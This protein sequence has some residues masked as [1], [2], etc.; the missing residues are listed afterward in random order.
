MNKPFLQDRSLSAIAG[1]WAETPEERAQI[2]GPFSRIQFRKVNLDSNDELKNF[3]LKEGWQPREWNYKK[4][5]KQKGRLLKDDQ[6]KPIVT[7]PKI[8]HDDPF[9]GIDGGLGRLASKRVQARSRKSILEG[10]ERSVRAD[11][12]VSQRITGIA[13][14]GR[15]THSGIVNVPGNES[16]FGVQMRKVF[17]APDPFVLVGTDSA[18]CQDRMLLGRANEYGVNDPVFEDMLLNGN[19]SKGTDSHSR[20]ATELN[21]VFKRNGIA[22]LTRGKAKN[23]NYA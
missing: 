10:W 2:G 14:T 3:L 15:L 6:G 5:P 1:R 11:G 20:A 13:S 19:K 8:K 12:T 17:V 18:G 7:S 9:V 23:F 16:F 4:D 21:K 22:E